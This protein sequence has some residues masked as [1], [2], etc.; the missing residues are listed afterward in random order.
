MKNAQIDP[1]N[2]LRAMKTCSDGDGALC[3]PTQLREID[4]VTARLP[5][6]CAT[7]GRLPKP[8]RARSETCAA[9]L[10]RCPCALR[11]FTRSAHGKCDGAPVRARALLPPLGAPS[12]CAG[13]CVMSLP[14]MHM[15]AG[16]TAHSPRVPLVALPPAGCMHRECMYA[17]SVV[18]EDPLGPGT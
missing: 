11:A 16:Q 10:R 4:Q 3:G 18:L 5:P 14:C 8:A 9:C 7:P 13:G 12:T 17:G 15:H 1:R 2:A 6:S